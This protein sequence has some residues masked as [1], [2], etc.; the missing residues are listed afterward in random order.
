MSGALDEPTMAG[1]PDSEPPRRSRR[2][3]PVIVGAIAVV[4]VGVFIVLVGA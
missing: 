1:V 4:M 3:A 2:I